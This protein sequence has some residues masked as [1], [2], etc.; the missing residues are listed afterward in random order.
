MLF[1]SF[2]VVPLLGR[3]SI[4]LSAS[5]IGYA[6]TGVNLL[7]IAMLMPSGMAVDR[8]G[9]KLVIAPPT[10]ICGLALALWAWS[11]DFPTFVLAAAVWGIGSGIS[12]PSPAAYLADLAPPDLRGRMFGYFRSVSDFGYIIG[13]L[14]L[15]WLIDSKGYAFPLL[16][17]GSMFVFAGALFWLFAPEFHHARHSAEAAGTA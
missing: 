17:T 15:G 9:R 16:M 10:I 7:N 3:E 11:H 6:M 14:L 1:R 12:G 8:I 13:P 2:T 5:Q 4:G